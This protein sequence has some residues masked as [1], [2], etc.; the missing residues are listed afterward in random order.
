MVNSKV[1]GNYLHPQN[2]E[3]LVN[4][5]N[6]KLEEISSFL[7]F[8]ENVTLEHPVMFLMTSGGTKPYNSYLWQEVENDKQ[9]VE[10]PP[11]RFVYHYIEYNQ[12]I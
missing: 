8:R 3:N 1:E 6:L 7:T 12:K 2:R 4:Y 5:P 11:P 10:R 9:L